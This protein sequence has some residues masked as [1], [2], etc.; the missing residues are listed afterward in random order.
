MSTKPPVDSQANLR[1]VLNDIHYLREGAETQLSQMRE[2]EGEYTYLQGYLAG[3]NA[4]A[5][6]LKLRIVQQ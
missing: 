6:E 2:G 4:A 3:L 5:A 1:E